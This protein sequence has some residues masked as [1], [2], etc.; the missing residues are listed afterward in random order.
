LGP[1]GCIKKQFRKRF[2]VGM[3]RIE[4]HLP[5]KFAQV[6]A[7]RLTGYQVMDATVRQ[8]FRQQLYLGRFTTP[9]DTF[10]TNEHGY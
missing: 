8:E 9:F 4:Q 6:G 2:H 1:V 7:T 5:D 10:E 3:G